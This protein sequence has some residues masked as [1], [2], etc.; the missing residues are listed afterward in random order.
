MNR[1]SLE[2]DLFG[3][4]TIGDRHLPSHTGLQRDPLI[5]RSFIRHRSTQLVAADRGTRCR[6]GK[7]VP[8]P[9]VAGFSL[10]DVGSHLSR[11]PF[12]I[13]GIDELKLALKTGPFEWRGAALS[14]S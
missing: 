9:E 8:S 6:M 14:A 7:S 10:C 12:E 1:S 4:D 5:R 2:R 3:A 13:L 11:S